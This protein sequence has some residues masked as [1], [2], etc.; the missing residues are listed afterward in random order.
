MA[1][2]VSSDHTA[3]TPPDPTPEPAEKTRGKRTGDT[4][5]SKHHEHA[6]IRPATSGTSNLNPGAIRIGR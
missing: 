3:I 4:H 1:E 2:F 6:V 5:A